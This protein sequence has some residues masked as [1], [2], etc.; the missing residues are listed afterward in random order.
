VNRFQ[1]TVYAVIPVY[2]RK[3]Y[4]KK[5]L[6]C[7]EVQTW[8]NLQVIVVDDGSN[9]GTSEMIENEFPMVTLINGDGTLWWTGAINV[10]IQCALERASNTDYILVINDDLEVD[11]NYLE[12][13]IRFA[14]AHPKTLVGSV[15]V[16]INQPNVVYNGGVLINWWNAKTLV[17]DRGKELSKFENGY[18]NEVSTLTGRGTLIPVGVF[19][20]IGLYDDNH[21]QQCG[22]TELPVRAIKQ[23]YKLFVSYKAV[24]K[25]HLNG[26]DYINVN[27]TY[28]LQDLKKYFFGIKSN[29]RLKYRF[30]FARS[31]SNKN[32]FRFLVFFTMDMIRISFYFLRQIRI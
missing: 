29:M 26:G 20:Q 32:P 23:G 19:K 18:Y 10:G 30:Y 11:E 3:H 5:C 1:P 22:D 14:Q 9:D 31:F 13:L 12:I 15:M 25:S 2:N 21:F 7:L 24:V 28:R 17:L 6:Y 27:N 8:S 4:T 16:D